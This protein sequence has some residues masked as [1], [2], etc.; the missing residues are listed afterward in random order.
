MDDGKIR[1]SG[2]F[3]NHHII[4]T[5]TTHGIYGEYNRKPIENQISYGDQGGYSRYFSLDKW[6]DTT[7]PFLAIP[8]AS[9]SERNKGL[10]KWMERQGSR[11]NSP[12][13]TGKFPE[14][15]HRILK[16]NPTGI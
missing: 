11:P 14:H 10:D 4:D 8:K 16:W 5:P 6:F 9:S 2:K 3:E 1:K 7:F 13:P 12:D 15:D